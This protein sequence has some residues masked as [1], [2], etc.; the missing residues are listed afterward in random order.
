[1]N[2]QKILIAFIIITLSGCG[3]SDI[4]NKG[5]DITENNY[6]KAETAKMFN[7]WNKLGANKKIAHMRN[8]PPRGDKAPVV[9]MNDDTLYSVILT[10]A[11]K[12]NEITFTIPETN[13]YTAV[14][15]INEGG[16]GEY[17]IVED[18]THTVKIETQYAFVLYRTGMENGL[19]GARLA[20]DRIEDA[21]KK[22]PHIFNTYKSLKYNQIQL[23]EYTQKLRDETR[24]SVFVYT[25][26]RESSLIT[27]RHQWNLENANG[28]GGASPE[29]NIGNKY[30]NSM[31]QDSSKCLTTTFKDPMSVFFT[32]ITAYDKNRYLL[33]GVKNINS[34]TW[35]K[36]TDGTITASF[37]CG[38]NAINNINTKGQDYT[39]TLRYY[40]VSQ[41]VIDNEIKPESTIK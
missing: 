36:N 41:Y 19:E 13:V 40:G 27:D 35:N 23:T 6:A 39:F 10:E 18:G 22:D 26:P 5:I 15:V 12:N 16:H 17:Y 28:W 2:K 29:E 38:D 1:M 20:Q 30:T 32:S 8:L 4:E 31:M 34:H 24:G 11:N 21:S 25:F 37:N 33:E 3:S 7:N 14:Q 9:Q